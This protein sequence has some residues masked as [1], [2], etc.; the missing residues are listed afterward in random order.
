MI[1]TASKL[2]DKLLNIYTTQYDKLSKDLNNR[3]NVLNKPE[4][5]DFDRDDPPPMLVLEGDE[6]V[7]SEPE[8]TIAERVEL[9][10]RERKNERTGLKILTPN[11]PLTRLPILL[12]Q[13]KAGNNSYKLKN[14]I[15]QILYLLYHHNKITKKVCN[16]LTKSLQS[17]K[18]T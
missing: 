6:E 2:Y 7:K 3:I 14:Q 5:L 13:L 4:I 15:R 17:W 8:E 9:N 11:K 12:A 16:N 18:K 10:P 1:N